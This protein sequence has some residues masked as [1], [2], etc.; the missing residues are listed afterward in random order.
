[1]SQIWNLT[2]YASGGILPLLVHGGRADGRTWRSQP[3]RF[4]TEW[5]WKL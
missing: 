5:G 2:K 4:T 1:M 3:L